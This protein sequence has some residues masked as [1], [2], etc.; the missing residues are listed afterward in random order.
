MVSTIF[1]GNKKPLPAIEKRSEEKPKLDAR[2]LLHVAAPPRAGHARKVSIVRGR[3]TRAHR[4]HR[5]P[6]LSRARARQAR[7]L[8]HAG[9]WQAQRLG[10]RRTVA[11]E[12]LR[13]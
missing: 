11:Q 6:H 4:S 5:P 3:E 10:V 1:I 13:R 8:S 12:P 7:G 9:S 2:R